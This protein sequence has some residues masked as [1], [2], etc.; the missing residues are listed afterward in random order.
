MCD[1][2]RIT[3]RCGHTRE[4][5]TYECIAYLS[6]RRGCA[7]TRHESVNDAFSGNIGSALINETVRLRMRIAVCPLVSEVHLAVSYEGRMN[8][9]GWN[10]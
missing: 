1:W 2:M 7:L 8:V 10:H 9:D 3:Y 6:G 5:Y 4:Y